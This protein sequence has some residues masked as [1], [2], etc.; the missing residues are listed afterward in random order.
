VECDVPPGVDAEKVKKW[1]ELCEH[2]GVARLCLIVKDP[3][4]RAFL[5]SRYEIYEK[6][7]GLRQIKWMPSLERTIDWIEKKRSP[8]LRVGVPNTAGKGARHWL[9][10]K[11]AILEKGESV[12]FYFSR[13]GAMEKEDL[14]CELW[15]IPLQEGTV[16]F[17]GKL[18]VVLDRFL[19]AP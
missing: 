2:Y 3:Q 11:R 1:A 6:G 8:V 12:M 13:A 9:D 10:L 18:A 5:K 19:G 15:M 4:N 16:P 17:E 7:R 14:R